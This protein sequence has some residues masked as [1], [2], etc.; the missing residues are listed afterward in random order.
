MI[1]MFYS[2]AFRMPTSWI[3][4]RLYKSTLKKWNIR[5]VHGFLRVCKFLIKFF[6]T[7]NFEKL[8]KN[9]NEWN[10]VLQE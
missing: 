10:D 3:T 4:Y 8:V 1:Q 7:T 6:A 2:S 9:P 5:G